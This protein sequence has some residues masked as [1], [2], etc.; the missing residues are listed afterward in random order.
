MLDIA[1]WLN[2]I[3]YRVTTGSKWEW[4]CFGNNAHF[5]SHFREG[6]SNSVD[7]TFD[8]E[9][10]VVYILEAVDEESGYAYRYFNPQFRQQYL[11]EEKLRGGPDVKWTELEVLSD[12][13]QKASAIVNG[14][15]YD[16][17]IQVEID[18]EDDVFLHLAK[19]A[20]KRDITINEMIAITIE[21]AL[22]MREFSEQQQ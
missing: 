11:D 13:Y 5:M 16:K 4:N 14:R 20:H 21:N 6:T 12:W 10:K 9:T 7:I 3:N 18:I 1:S 19:E 15:E 8:T 22:E 17:R 2:V